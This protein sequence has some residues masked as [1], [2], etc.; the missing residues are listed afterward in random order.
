[1]GYKN[2]YVCP[3]HI[4]NR[5]MYKITNIRMCVDGMVMEGIIH[6]FIMH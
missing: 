2:I 4:G 5:V 1:M 6:S 3:G